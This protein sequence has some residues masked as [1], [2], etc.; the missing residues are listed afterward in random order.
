MYV[1]AKAAKSG[2]GDFH[3]FIKDF[4]LQCFGKNDTD[5]V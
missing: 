5:L 1:K 2:F 4:I 3:A